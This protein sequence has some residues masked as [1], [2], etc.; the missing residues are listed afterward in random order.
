[1][2]YSIFLFS[3]LFLACEKPN[4]VSEIYNFEGKTMGTYYS[5][6]YVSNDEQDLQHSVDSILQFVN[7]SV[8]TYI[9]NSTISK[10]NQMGIGN[11][12]VD[13]HFIENFVEAKQVYEKTNGSFNPAVMPLVNYWGFG[14]ERLQNEQPIDSTKVAELL[15][16]VNFDSFTLLDNQ[17][18]KAIADAELD[19]SSLAKGYGVD[20]IA[21]Y[22]NSKQIDSY[23]IDIGG[24]VVANGVKP[25]NSN[26]TVGIRKPSTNL[27]ERTV[28]SKAISLKNE[29]MATSGNYE[30][31]K[32]LEG[33]QI[34]AHTINPKTGFPQSLEEEILSSTVIAKHC[35]TADAYA[36]AFKVMGLKKSKEVIKNKPELEVFFIY[37]T[38]TGEIKNWTT[39][40]ELTNAH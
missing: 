25:D 26:W 39:I 34:I 27:N 36:T 29:A 6:Q 15:Q 7:Q 38:E 16:L 30:N 20:V 9:P 37:K 33:R 28:V 2:K 4:L 22:F 23:L 40:E 21:N 32:E 35:I 5:V 17:L 10:V 11:I 13:S 14:Y 1:M 18:T 3:F 8:S 12:E 24:E 31:Y 19:F